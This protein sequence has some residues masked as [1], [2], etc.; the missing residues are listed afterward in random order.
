V[1]Q[2]NSLPVGTKTG[3]AIILRLSGA[4][5]HRADRL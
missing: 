3:I 1:R 2:N 5:A 4:I